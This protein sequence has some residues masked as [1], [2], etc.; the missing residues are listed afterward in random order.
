[1]LMNFLKRLSLLKNQAFEARQAGLRASVLGA[2][3]VSGL[4]SGTVS[5]ALVT[6][7]FNGSFKPSQTVSEAEDV[8]LAG[9]VAPLLGVGSS[10]APKTFSVTVSLDAAATGVPSGTPGTQIYRTVV[11]SSSNF[12]GFSSTDRS[13]VGATG[14]FICTAFVFDGTGVFGGS[15]SDS[16]ALL[17]SLGRSIDFEAATGETRRLDFQFVLFFSDISGNALTSN[18]V[19]VDLSLLDVANFSGSFVV[20]APTIGAPGF[21]RADFDLQIDSVVTGSAPSNDVPEP[22]SLFLTALACLALGLSER[23]RAYLRALV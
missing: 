7:T 13:C 6:Y 4:F 11:S 22:G 19:D 23:R 21:D 20:F 9:A 5:A 12:A 16:F 8:L 18:S 15:G 10:L 2:A 3:L 14:D 1:M 17:P